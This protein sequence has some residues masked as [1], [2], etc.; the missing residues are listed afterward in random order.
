MREANAWQE[1]NSSYLSQT[2]NWLRLRLE[3]LAGIEE[4]SA[5]VREITLDPQ[6]PLSLRSPSDVGSMDE[7]VQKASKAMAAAEAEIPPPA[8]IF[9]SQLSLR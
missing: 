5:G 6:V 7:Y 3:R 8:L 9:M 4:C 2:I 1:F